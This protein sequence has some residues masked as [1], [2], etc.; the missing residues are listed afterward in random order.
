MRL[1]LILSCWLLSLGPT[2]HAATPIRANPTQPL[3]IAVVAGVSGQYV[4]GD[5]REP[6]VPLAIESGTRL[7]LAGAD[8]VTGSHSMTSYDVATG[9]IPL[10][11][12]D[13]VGAGQAV[14]VFGVANLLTGQYYFYCRNHFGMDGLLT[15][16]S[17]P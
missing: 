1:G 16:T 14:E 11:D 13:Q 2:S 8:P 6:S 7:F 10:F 3:G 9:G 17:R 12:S 15:V 4:P 5:V